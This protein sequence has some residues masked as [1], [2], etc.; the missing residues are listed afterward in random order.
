MEKSAKPRT[1]KPLTLGADDVILPQSGQYRCLSPYEAK[2]QGYWGLIYRVTISFPSGN[3]RDQVYCGSKSLAGSAWK[4]YETSSDTVGPLI[5]RSRLL[6]GPVVQWEILG[7][8]RSHGQA[9]AIEQTY[10]NKAREEHGARCMN[11]ADV[12]GK[13]LGTKPNKYSKRKVKPQSNIRYT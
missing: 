3:F 5:I 13:K 6:G 12:A 2:A 7:Y 9:L 1:P 10:I 4:S 8:A 11:R